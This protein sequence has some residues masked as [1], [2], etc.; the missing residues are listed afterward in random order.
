[1]DA[2]RWSLLAGCL[3]LFGCGQEPLP[4]TLSIN[5]QSSVKNT[6][7][8]G[9]P[10]TLPPQ[11]EPPLSVT[12]DGIIAPTPDE[13]SGTSESDFTVLC[14]AFV[15][16]DRDTWKAAERALLADPARAEPILADAIQNGAVY[17]RELA[18]ELL[19]RMSVQFDATQAA[20]NAA[21]AD[22]GSEF[23]RAYAALAVVRSHTRDSDQDP[24]LVRA[25]RSCLESE[26]PDLQ[27][28]GLECLSVSDTP[29]RA[30]V[31]SV[32]RLLGSQ[33]ADVR[34][35][36]CRAIGVVCED[37]QLAR[38]H[39]EKVVNA[40]SDPAVRRAAADALKSSEAS[41]AAE[42]SQGRNDQ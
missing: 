27:L 21:I 25:I 16:G 33:A 9:S 24:K 20:L 40:D 15:A 14:R 36:A 31:A 17:E 8:T 11:A 19:S 23:V 35:A 41:G 42:D 30:L 37:P 3:T 26:H 13:I 4:E 38:G 1:M 28:A 10:T 5:A 2:R 6:E 32:I 39:L 12:A 7:P 34:I 18:A 22:D 29:G